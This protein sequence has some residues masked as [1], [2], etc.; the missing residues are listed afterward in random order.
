MHN[1]NTS[2]SA[3]GARSGFRL[4]ISSLVCTLFLLAVALPLAYMAGVMVG[5]SCPVAPTAVERMKD[6]EQARVEEAREAREAQEAGSAGEARHAQHARTAKN[7][8][9]GRAG[10]KVP[11]QEEAGSAAGS[12]AILGPAELSYSRVLRAAP[13]EKVQEPKP[14]RFAPAVDKEKEAAMPKMAPGMSPAV[15]EGPPE[16]PAQKADAYDFVF[17]V[18]TV[19][20]L[21]KAE[22]L[23]LK[24]EEKGY[25]TR[26]QQQGRRVVVF[27]L[28]RGPEEKGAEVRSAMMRLHLGEPLERGRKPVFRPASLQ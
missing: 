25:R 9:D 11:A 10:A 6:E 5:R 28:A 23:R 19:D 1:A 15:I 21:A 13:G 3:S 27:V 20:S 26:L 17:Q 8:K 4:T 7:A 22:D 24:I 12:Q 16:P 18:A 2:S 14:V